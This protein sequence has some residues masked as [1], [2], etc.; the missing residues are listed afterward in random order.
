MGPD[1]AFY[2]SASNFHFSPGAPIL[3]SYDLANW[4]PIG[5]SVPTLDFGDNYDMV[6]GTAYRRGT[7]ASTLRYSKKNGL[8]YWYGCIDFWNSYMY[9]AP[10]VT[11]PWTRGAEFYGPYC[12]YDCG[13]FI[14]DD[15]TMYIV[16]GSNN[17][18]I[19][20]L[21]ADG[22]TMIRTEHMLSTPSQFGGIE[23]NRMYKRNGTYYILDD[24][25]DSGATLIWKS[26]SIWGPWVEKTLQ[27]GLAGPPSVGGTPNQGSLIE[28]P[29][30]DWYFMSFS[31]NYPLGRMPVL[32]PLTWGTDGYPLITTSNNA[33]ADSYLMP[34]PSNVTYSWLGTDTFS[35]T[36]LS[37]EWEWNH[38]PDTTKYTINNG[39][40]L[41]T[42]TITTDIYNARNTL[43]HRLMGPSSTATI[44]LD[45]TNM[46]DGDSAGFA[47]FRDWTAYI[48]ITRNGSTYTVSNVQGALQNSSTW[49][50]ITDGTT[51]ASAPITSG[52]V[53]LRGVA[54]L[55]GTNSDHGVSFSYSTDGKIFSDLGSKY[56]M[57]T[58]YS[59]FVG[60]RWAI[61]NFATKALGGSIFV[62]SFTMA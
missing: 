8:W 42:A 18:N 20:Q 61:F 6:G 23:G 55:I 32:A 26:S 28:T 10:S 37:P 5:H 51:I 1:G 40:A 22:T 15:D 39:V 13:L 2:F 56:T 58:D 25:P 21:S 48:G 52:K 44:V 30:G 9:S 36:T 59:L 3:K 34:L 47:A 11:G 41:S 43:T 29:S 60:Y 27:Q 54:D 19:T 62:S 53:W 35:G 7:W 49:A 14:D 46:V 24:S 4:T 12:F 16:Y 17:V 57:N 38:N 31:W 33:W 50:T 45:I